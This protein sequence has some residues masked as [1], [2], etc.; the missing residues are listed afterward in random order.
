MTFFTPKYLLTKKDNSCFVL[1]LDISEQAT[2]RCDRS[3]KRGKN[4]LS[5]ALAIQAKACQSRMSHI[6]VAHA[7]HAQVLGARV[8]RADLAKLLQACTGAFK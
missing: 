8:Q 1:V 5:Q 3:G 7:H 2:M 6:I 4:L